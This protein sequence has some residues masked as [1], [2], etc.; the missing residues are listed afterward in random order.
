MNR[1]VMM[2]LKNIVRVPGLW[3]KLCRYAKHPEN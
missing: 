1:L 3:I 2:V